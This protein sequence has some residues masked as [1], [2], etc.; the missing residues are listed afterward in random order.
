MCSSCGKGDRARL[1]GGECTKA[2]QHACTSKAAGDMLRRASDVLVMHTGVGSAVLRHSACN[3][4]HASANCMHLAGRHLAHRW[5][6]AYLK[7]TASAQCLQLPDAQ[8]Q[9]AVHAYV[10]DLELCLFLYS[11]GWSQTL[12]LIIIII[13]T[14]LMLSV[15]KGSWKPCLQ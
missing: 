2:G 14:I 15:F 10:L 6:C 3:C 12:A 11:G 1:A 13:I 9:I 8:A 5:W 4:C 7:F